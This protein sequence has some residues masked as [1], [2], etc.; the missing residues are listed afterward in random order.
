MLMLGVFLSAPL[1]AADGT[2][3]VPATLEDVRYDIATLRREL[4]DLS[5]KVGNPTN[6]GLGGAVED[7]AAVKAAV[8]NRGVQIV[9][10]R[11]IAPVHAAAGWENP[12]G[13]GVYDYAWPM[14]PT[15]V[16][17]GGSIPGVA[18]NASS[19]V[20]LPPGTYLF[21]MLPTMI[22]SGEYPVTEYHELDFAAPSSIKSAY[23]RWVSWRWT[24]AAGHAT[25]RIGS[26][27]V[28][29]MQDVAVFTFASATTIKG[30][31]PHLVNSSSFDENGGRIFPN[32]PDS[33]TVIGVIERL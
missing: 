23:S 7:L 15:H 20:T 6:L 30:Y 2:D 18:V 9:E 4:A 12:L 27:A 10:F 5:T 32:R 14:T 22:G 25:G 28:W 13:S 16:N 31:H 21:Q 29:P 24:S 33:V 11:F 8:T 26:D 1:F 19:G 17:R 3:N